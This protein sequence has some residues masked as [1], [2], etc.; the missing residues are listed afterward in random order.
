MKYILTGFLLF[1]FLMTLTQNAWAPP[2]TISPPTS[3]AMCVANPCRSGQVPIIPGPAGPAGVAGRDG[4]DGMPGSAGACPSSCCDGGGSSSGLIY[5]V[6]A[7]EQTLPCNLGQ[8]RCGA[9]GTFS[10]PNCDPGDIELDPLNRLAASTGPNSIT[11]IDGIPTAVHISDGYV[12]SP[13]SP[14]SVRIMAVCVDTS[15]PAHTPA[16]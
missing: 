11:S 16:L 9:N 13:S 5:T 2:R 6:A 1:G 4:R 12:P 7:P 8:F 10:R 3:G 15:L 14:A